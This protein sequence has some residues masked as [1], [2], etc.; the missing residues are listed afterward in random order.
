MTD[1][2]TGGTIAVSAVI[3]AHNVEPYLAEAV[4]SALSQTFQCH[5]VIIVDDGSTDGTIQEARAFG[6]KVKVIQTQQGGAARARN[7]GVR[8][9]SGT[10]IAFLDADDVWAPRKIERQVELFVSNPE[11]GLVTTGDCVMG[12]QPHG[13]SEKRKRLFE[14]G[15]VAARILLR[16]GLATP[17]VM[18]PKAV[19]EAVGGFDESLA[20]GEDD[21]L[22]IRIASRYPVALIDEI[23]VWIR[24]RPGSLTTDRLRLYDHALAALDKLTADPIA[25]AAVGDLLA[26]KR[27][28]I[29]ADRGYTHFAKLDLA[30]A[31]IACRAALK[32][33][34]RN[35]KAW[36]YLV[37]SSM[38]RRLILALRRVQASLRL[39]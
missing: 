10:H 35:M 30:A 32:Y 4:E 21:H 8:A 20:L 7:L 12:T 19:F 26:L 27:S 39:R 24:Q 25:M 11:L 37:L 1:K 2:R 13:A 34:G 28:L 16:S 33:D 36:K 38:P 15:N 5:E 31:R 14:G 9:A 23:L 17:T 22:W 18:L 6:N 3:P 29:Y